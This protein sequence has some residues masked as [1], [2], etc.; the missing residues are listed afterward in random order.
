M[1]LPAAVRQHMRLLPRLLLRRKKEIA[2]NPADH[3]GNRD[4]GDDVRRRL[5]KIKANKRKEKGS[6]AKRKKKKRK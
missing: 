6:R 1:L 2:A 4:I 5:G 3:F